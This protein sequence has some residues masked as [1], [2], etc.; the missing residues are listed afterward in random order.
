[1]ETRSRKLVPKSL[2]IPIKPREG[3]LELQLGDIRAKLLQAGLKGKALHH[4]T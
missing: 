2:I 3:S 1:M 4:V